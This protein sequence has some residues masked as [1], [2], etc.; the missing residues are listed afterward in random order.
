[1][2][3]KYDF[4]EKIV[5]V[6]GGTKGIGK[7]LAEAFTICG[8]RVI[9]TYSSDDIAAQNLINSDSTGLLEVVKCDVSSY[10][11][12]ENFFNDLE[13][14][15]ISVDVLINNAGV[16]RDSVL[17]MMKEDDWSRVIDINLTPNRGDCASI[18]GIARDLSATEGV[19]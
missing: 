12:V 19:C 15:K 7:A 3:I 11:A 2:N 9:V 14:K 4:S 5:I 17:G 6:T 8:A 18:H 13:G 1:M 10:S 16:R